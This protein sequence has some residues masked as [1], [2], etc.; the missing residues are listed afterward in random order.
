MSLHCSFES[1]NQTFARQQG[2]SQHIKHYHC[3]VE[4]ELIVVSEDNVNDYLQDEE[5]FKDLDLFKRSESV[6]NIQDHYNHPSFQELDN[7][8]EIIT[9]LDDGNEKIINNSEDNNEEIIMEGLEDETENFMD[10]LDTETD[11]VDSD[12]FCEASFEDAVNETL[13]DNTPQWPN[14]TYQEFT[15]ICVNNDLSNQ[16]IDSFIQKHIIDFEG[17]KYFLHYHPIIKTIKA[18]LQKEDITNNFVF[19]FIKIQKD[20]SYSQIFAEQYNCNWWQQTE[21]ELK[22]GCHILLILYSDATLC[23]N[24]GKIQQ[25]PVF[26][27]LDNI[28]LWQRNKKDAKSIMFCPILKLKEMEFTVKGVQVT[29]AS[30]ISIFIA[31][32]L[33]ANAITSAVSRFSGLKIFSNGI[34]IIQTANEYQMI[35]KVIIS[36]LDSIFDDKNPY[37]KERKSKKEFSEEDLNEFENLIIKWSCEFVNTFARFNPSNLRLPKLHFWRYHIIPAIRQFGIVNEVMNQILNRVQQKALTEI[38]KQTKIREKGKLSDNMLIISLDK[39]N[40]FIQ[41]Y[42]SATLASTDIIHADPSYNNVPWFSDVTIVMD[43]AEINNYTTDQGICF[44]KVLLLGEII[45]NSNINAMNFTFTMIKWYNY[46]QDNEIYGCPLLL[47]LDSYDIVP[48]DSIAYKISY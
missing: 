35:I 17:I 11:S 26:L 5:L 28:P 42:K 10:D 22:I 30:R 34:D 44:G 15:K 21:T 8:K 2:L 9:V 4:N 16:A 3:F 19:Q 40:S 29:F 38:T 14:E 37:I 7:S 18:L 31:N 27:T 33:E 32:M 45:I 6:L 13:D 25:H 1:C 47:M 41:L 20:G 39:N 36:I 24:L 23:D 12:D 43:E 48:L 46:K